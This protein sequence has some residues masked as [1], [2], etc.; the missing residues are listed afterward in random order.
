M[1]G[2]VKGSGMLGYPLNIRGDRGSSRRKGLTV[3]AASRR[4]HFPNL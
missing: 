4:A 1:V 2:V 3:Y